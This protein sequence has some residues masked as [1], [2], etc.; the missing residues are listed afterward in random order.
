[1]TVTAPFP[2]RYVV[3]LEAGLLSADPRPPIPA[4]TP[5]QFGGSDKVWSPEELLVA[6]VLLC[7]KT[8]FDAYARRDSL[9]VRDWRGTG[10]GVLEK[11][12]TGPAFTSVQL[13]VELKVCPGDEERARKLLDTAEHH[14]IIANAIKAPVQLE[15]SVRSD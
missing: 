8:T 4:G 9:E 7:L 14:C 13:R 6:A 15:A 2:H 11:S 12:P 1:M 10:T 3:S 5:P